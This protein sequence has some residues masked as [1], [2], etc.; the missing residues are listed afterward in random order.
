M[1][2][3]RIILVGGVI[4]FIHRMHDK[5]QLAE[6]AFNM[7]SELGQAHSTCARVQMATVMGKRQHR[8]FLEHHESRCSLR[9]LLI[10][11]HW[12]WFLGA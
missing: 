10:G 4:T 6:L 12:T 2:V 5:Q 11:N 8:A 9:G 7:G 3:M 1:S